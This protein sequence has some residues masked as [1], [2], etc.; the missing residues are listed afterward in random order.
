ME[1]TVTRRLF[2]L[3]PHVSIRMRY[4]LCK[5]RIVVLQH[6]LRDVFRSFTTKDDED[7]KKIVCRMSLKDPKKGLVELAF[8]IFGRYASISGAK[9]ND[10]CRF[11]ARW[12]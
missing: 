1:D 6:V 5:E 8:L 10:P 4:I 12:F 3:M 2:S 9:V 11:E 7:A